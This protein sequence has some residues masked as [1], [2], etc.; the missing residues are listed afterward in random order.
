[1]SNPRRVVLVLLALTGT[2]TAVGL[3]G[4]RAPR[5]SRFSAPLE[6][7]VEAIPAVGYGS[8]KTPAKTPAE[9]PALEL[10]PQL[11]TGPVVDVTPNSKTVVGST[12]IEVTVKMCV[13]Y[14]GAG[15]ASRTFSLS[16]ASGT[17]DVSGSFSDVTSELGYPADCNGP[18]DYWEWWRGTISLEPGDNNL[19]VT[20]YDYA[21]FAGSERVTYTLPAP[22]RSVVV[23]ADA[24]S[25]DRTASQSGSAR[26]TVTNTG[27]VTATY[28]LSQSCTGMGSCGG[29]SPGSLSLGAG[30]TGSATISYTAPGT[31]GA[32][33]VINLTATNTTPPMVKDASWME[34]NVVA[35]PPAGAVLAGTGTGGTDVLER[36]LCL[37]VAAGSG[38]AVEC[39]E[40]RAAHALPMVRTLNTPRVPTLLYNSGHAHPMPVVHAD[41]TLPSGEA[42]PATV[43]AT[44]S[45]N[46]TQ[47]NGSWNG[48]DWVAGETRRIALQVDAS[49]WNTGLY[50]Y[51]LEIRRVSGSSTVFATIGDRLPVVNLSASPFGAGW[52]LAGVERLYDP[53]DGS[54]F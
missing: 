4:A 33:G 10:S 50:P 29:P 38:L 1:M 5:D 28:S 21:N 11:M 15:I 22:E 31:L 51:T 27:D 32:Q 53:G 6:T 40:L 39:G 54:R 42:L 23:M 24:Q 12:T 47:I 44:L 25:V 8:A 35:A 46:G 45:V 18:N 37:T 19:T 52:W 48:N 30:Q 3:A 34:V 20:A 9:I 16:K 49:G 13:L 26:F 41:V 43:E 36:G 17:T 2:V 7:L 14:P